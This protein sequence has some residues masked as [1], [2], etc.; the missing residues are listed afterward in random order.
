MAS[1]DP[2]HSYFGKAQGRMMDTWVFH[3][4]Q[5]GGVVDGAGCFE[6]D[7]ERDLIDHMV[8]AH[9]FPEAAIL[10]TVLEGKRNAYM[11][12]VRKMEQKL[13]ELEKRAGV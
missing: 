13:A 8:Q 5:C 11:K 12:R 1:A 6:F 2:C 3:C 10:L 4:C 7:T 9:G